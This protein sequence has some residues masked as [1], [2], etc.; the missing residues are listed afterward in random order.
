M[1]GIIGAMEEEIAKLKSIMEK[2]EI[3]K[4]A[5]MEFYCGEIVGKPVIVVRSGIGKVNA[6]ACTQILADKFNVDTVI[7]TG[8]AG[9][10]RNEINIGDIVLSTDA[11]NH[12]MNVEGFGY[13]R[14]QVPG[15]DVFAFPTDENLRKQAKSIC[16]KYIDVGVHEG[17]ILSGDVFVSDRRIKEDLQRTFDGF[18]AEMEGAAIA[19]VAYLNNIKCLIIRAISDKADDSASVD[20]PEFEKQAIKNCVKLTLKLIENI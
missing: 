20:Y 1:I 9:S 17:R 14:G 15:M 8:I 10:L 6:A 7:N 18:C 2:V 3:E 13:P 4:I 19:Q 11:V 5:G 16:E 12:D